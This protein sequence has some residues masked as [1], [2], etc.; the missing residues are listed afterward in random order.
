MLINRTQDVNKYILLILLI[1]LGFLWTGTAYIAQ[2]Y[3]LLAMLDGGTVNLITCG[4]Y[5]VC[6]AAGIGG[7][8]L[9]FW[10][11]PAF[12]G[13][14]ALPICATAF[15]A[16]CTAVSLYSASLAVII[17]FGVLLN[18][19]IGVLSGCYLTRLAT[20]IPQQRRGLVFGCAYALGSIGTWLISLPMGG[21]FLWH[22][23]SFFAIIALA[24]LTVPRI[25]RLSPPTGGS[26]IGER[27]RE[28][29][30]KKLIFLAAAVLF[31]LSMENTL[32]FAFP[33]KGASGSVY[34]E[35][36]RVF[37]GVGLV[38]AGFVSDKNRRSGAIC[39]L[40]AL[41]F[42]FGALALGS[43]MA[44]ETVMWM[45]A[46]LFL[47]FWSVY[48]ILVF[49]DISGKAGI[50][51]LAVFGLL[52]GRLGEAAGTLGAGLFTGTPLIV[53]SGAVFVAVIALFFVLYQKLYTSVATP[54]ELERKRFAEYSARF[55]F[56]ARE[57]EIFA[58]IIRGMS[59]AEIAGTLYITESTVKFHIGN[60]FKKSGF[61][62]RSELITDYKLGN[63]H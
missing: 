19:A 40:A 10:V 21:R 45:L 41:A 53:I 36:T 37:Y 42:P 25:L 26:E 60:M 29:F 39:C 35:F 2:A 28:G 30:G 18:L 32:G 11:R 61:T 48:R 56:S 51:A 13:G 58:L 6:Q 34:I 23:E 33:L 7:A 47:G 5:Y 1:G 63:T 4:A 55:G 38:V 43:N 12:A 46:Y 3:K 62:R 9:L 20:D 22:S 54:E 44:G 49:S 14:K 8:A 52:F 17:S 24:A 15:A 31:L 27:P 50:P 57:Q 16:V 59:N